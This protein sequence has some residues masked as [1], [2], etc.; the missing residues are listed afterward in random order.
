MIVAYALP[1]IEEAILSTYRKAEISSKFKMWKDAMVEEISTLYK[2]NT[3]E[4]TKLPK[5]KK[6]IGYKWYM[7]RNRD[8]SKM[9]LYTIKS[10]W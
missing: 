3:W 4:V 1:V 7:Q 8:L 5:G 6:T 2:N 10:D 9:I